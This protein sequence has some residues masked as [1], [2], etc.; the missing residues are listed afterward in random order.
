[1]PQLGP[2]WR[3]SCMCTPW[4][5]HQGV[6]NCKTL[7]TIRV[8]V[9][10][11]ISKLWNSPLQRTLPISENDWPV[12]THFNLGKSRNLCYVEW[13]KE[14]YI[15]YGYTCKKV[16]NREAQERLGGSVGIVS[17]FVSGHDLVVS[18]FKPSVRLCADSLE[19]GACFRF[20][21]SLSLSAPPLLML[22][23]SL[24]LSQK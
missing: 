1:M 5:T 3:I 4:D 24:S 18:E 13:E 7:E 14:R 17:D 15:R 8:S 19:P 11:K 22:C 21:V 2:H 20:C 12:A 23:L 9:D 10:S 6:C 16:K